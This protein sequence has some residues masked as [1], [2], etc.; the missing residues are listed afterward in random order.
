MASELFR[1]FPPRQ[2]H[3]GNFR[4]L[5][6]FSEKNTLEI[7]CVLSMGEAGAKCRRWGHGWL[8]LKIR[9]GS[10]WKVHPWGKS[11]ELTAMSLTPFCTPEPVPKLNLWLS[12]NCRSLSAFSLTDNHEVSSLL[13]A[14]P[15]SAGNPSFFW[16][17]TASSQ[18]E[19]LGNFLRRR[20][21]PV[22]FDVTCPMCQA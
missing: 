7:A 9:L 10:I 8:I 17:V 20:G 21:I 18:S 19:L 2:G 6:M 5:W 1:Q 16:A 14:L 13:P 3:S 22:T 15:S 12:P 4:A 11:R